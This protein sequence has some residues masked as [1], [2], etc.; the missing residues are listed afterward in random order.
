MAQVIAVGDYEIEYSWISERGA[1]Y[2]TVTVRSKNP[3]G[4]I[5]D[6][7]YVFKQRHATEDEALKAAREKAEIAAKHPDR[8]L[9][10]ADGKF[11]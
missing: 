2:A 6:V 7:G 8:N 3:I 9:A 1:Y 5:R 4:Q 11:A 10:G